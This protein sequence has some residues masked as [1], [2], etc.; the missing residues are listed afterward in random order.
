MG[1]PDALRP[2]WK[3]EFYRSDPGTTL[4]NTLQIPGFPS[5][6]HGWYC[7]RMDGPGERSGAERGTSSDLAYT[8]SI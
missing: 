2:S 8:K 7:K 5:A 3:P 1:P 4:S 6:T